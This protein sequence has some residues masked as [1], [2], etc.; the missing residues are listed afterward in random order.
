[1][2]ETPEDDVEFISEGSDAAGQM[3]LLTVVMHELGHVLG[4]DDLDPEVDDLMSATLD[5]GERQLPDDGDSG[6][7]VMDADTNSAEEPVLT[8]TLQNHSSWLT[9][10]LLEDAKGNYNPFEPKEDISIVLFDNNN[11]KEK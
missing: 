6:L 8:H 10:F 1:M 9:D 5:S 7:V 2:D 4:Y 11:K 3:D